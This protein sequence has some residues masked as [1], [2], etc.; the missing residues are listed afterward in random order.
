MPKAKAGIL[1][2]TK[3]ISDTR[4]ST[5]PIKIPD[6]V[7][8]DVL[9]CPA[10]CLPFSCLPLFPRLRSPCL[11]SPGLPPV[12]GL[13]SPCLRVSR[14]LL[15]SPP[16]CVASR[17]LKG[18][19]WNLPLRWGRLPS[20]GLSPSPVSVSPVSLSFPVSR[21]RFSCL[22]VFPSYFSKYVYPRNPSA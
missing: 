15:C 22:P 19:I 14:L 2:D 5:S 1:D 3:A 21:L 10:S 4:L 9:V 13:R 7:R 20:H 16:A 6:Q 8:D 11:P 17:L 12:S 18:Q